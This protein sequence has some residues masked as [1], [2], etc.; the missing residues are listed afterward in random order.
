M[1]LF[2]HQ[3]PAHSCWAQVAYLEWALREKDWWMWLQ[4]F[5]EESHP[6]PYTLVPLL[7]E[8]DPTLDDQEPSLDMEEDMEEGD[9]DVGS[10]AFETVMDYER[11]DLESE[12]DESDAEPE[13]R[14]DEPLFDPCTIQQLFDFSKTH[15]RA[16]YSKTA[17]CSFDKEL[18]AYGLLD[19]D[20]MGEPDDEL[21]DVDDIT[22]DI[23][24]G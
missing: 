12:E 9:T 4:E 10:G 2:N 13:F 6:S 23:L 20:A 14:G 19:L 7:I 18:G 3:K 22:R 17:L 11:Q 5:R 24:I 21:V 16:L 1:K 15:W 8:V